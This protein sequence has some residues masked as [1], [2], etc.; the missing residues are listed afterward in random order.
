M[1]EQELKQRL[2]DFS[3]Q[4]IADLGHSY[5]VESWREIL[6]IKRRIRSITCDGRKLEHMQYRIMDYILNHTSDD[7]PYVDK[8]KLYS[9]FGPYDLV[10]QALSNLADDGY[11]LTEFFPTCEG[12]TNNRGPYPLRCFPLKPYED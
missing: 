9:I 6:K 3:K 4:E 1:T 11:I 8:K 5:D 7:C 12:R 2:E 10:C